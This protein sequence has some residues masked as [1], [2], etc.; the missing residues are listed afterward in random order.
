MSGVDG[1]AIVGRLGHSVCTGGSPWTRSN[2]GVIGQMKLL[3]GEEEGVIVVNSEIASL[4]EAR[5]A[6]FAV[7]G[8][9]GGQLHRREHHGYMAEATNTSLLE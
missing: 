3:V 4:N 7:G 2:S 9:A 6:A 5:E 1:V 8:T